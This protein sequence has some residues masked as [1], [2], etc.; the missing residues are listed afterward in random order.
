M[1]RIY[2]ATISDDYSDSMGVVGAYSTQHQAQEAARNAVSVRGFET[3]SAET[4]V[5]YLD[6]IDEDD[7]STKDEI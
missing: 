1:T 2:V 4:M 6:D 3:W 7:K 5:Y